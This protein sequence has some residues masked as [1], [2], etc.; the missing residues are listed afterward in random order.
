M[1]ESDESYAVLFGVSAGLV[2][3]SSNGYTV[4]KNGDRRTF[5][6]AL[7]ISRLQ[8]GSLFGARDSVLELG[9]VRSQLHKIWCRH[10]IKIQT[11]CVNYWLRSGFLFDV[12][13]PV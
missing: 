12:L 3:I 1:L 5:Q 7:R 10:A 9:N 6:R 2:L 11:T 13:G 8:L 4:A